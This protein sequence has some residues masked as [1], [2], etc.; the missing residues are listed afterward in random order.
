MNKLESRKRFK[1]HRFLDEGIFGVAKRTVETPKLE[2][3]KFECPRK[4]RK[5]SRP[6]HGK[7]LYSTLLAIVCRFRHPSSVFVV[8]QSY[9]TVPKIPQIKINH[10]GKFAFKTFVLFVRRRLGACNQ[11]VCHSGSKKLEFFNWARSYSAR[12]TRMK[13]KTQSK[14][15]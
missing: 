8:S 3:Q 7:L 5:Q 2:R 9:C 15:P 14:Q 10:S 12:S 6:G 11:M 4:R 1:I 13:Q